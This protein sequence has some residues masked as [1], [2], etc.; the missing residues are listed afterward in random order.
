MGDTRKPLERKPLERK[1][2]ETR[3][4]RRLLP[5]VRRY[6]WRAGGAL[7]GI[8]IVDAASVLQPWLVKIAIDTNVAARDLAG[9][10]R[11]GVLLGAVLAAAYIFQVI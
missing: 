9:L 6:A 7:L 4:L 2:L 1:P 10:G 3:L 8:V 11:T 5:Y